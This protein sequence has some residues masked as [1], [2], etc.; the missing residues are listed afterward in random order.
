MIMTLSELS[1]VNNRYIQLAKKSK[2]ITTSVK[3]R[4]KRA[5]I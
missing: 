4:K 1:K 5:D 2:V 3:L